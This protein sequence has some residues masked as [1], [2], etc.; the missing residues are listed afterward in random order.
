MDSAN[1]HVVPDTTRDFPSSRRRLSM[2]LATTRA[3]ADAPGLVE[4]AHKVLAT[5]ADVEGWSAGILWVPTERDDRL[6]GSA[7]WT[8]PLHPVPDFERAAR[9]TRRSRAGDRR[10]R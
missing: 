6:R 3:I 8:A 4:A 2:L 9:S 10:A 1:A 7:V 5:V